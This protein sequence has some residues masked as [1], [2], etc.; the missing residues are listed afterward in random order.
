MMRGPMRGYDYVLSSG[1]SGFDISRIVAQEK[2][3]I[4][5]LHWIGGNS[6]RL[7]SL[8]G[9]KQPVVWRLSD[10]WPFCGLQHLEPEA[11]RYSKAPPGHF[12]INRPWT[13]LSEH[14]RYKKSKIY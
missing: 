14:V 1:A 7:E 5:Q 4:L 6:F 13:D 10:Q 8:A 12:S 11:Q 3:D 9:V 2:P